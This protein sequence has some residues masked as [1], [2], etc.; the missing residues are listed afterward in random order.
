MSYLL[1]TGIASWILWFFIAATR[2][3]RT[4]LRGRSA[5]PTGIVFWLFII[6]TV[7]DIAAIIG[8]V[9]AH[10]FFLTS[11]DYPVAFFN[12]ITT[13]TTLCFPLTS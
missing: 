11:Q 7:A 9:R 2:T 1:F 13:V 4:R 10:L 3:P 12:S 5:V 8:A 6:A